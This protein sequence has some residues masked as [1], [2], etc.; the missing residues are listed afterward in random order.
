MKLMYVSAKER[1]VEPLFQMSKDLI[2]KYIKS[3]VF[4]L[5]KQSEIHDIS[6]NIT[7]CI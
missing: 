6:G 4:V 7:E 5:Q 2:D 1:D 3:W